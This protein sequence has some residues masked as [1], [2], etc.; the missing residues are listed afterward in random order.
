MSSTICGAFAYTVT[1]NDGTAIDASVFTF[2]LGSGTDPNT[3]SI[4]TSNTA[5]VGVYTIIL[6]G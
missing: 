1:N 2:T 6:T 3:F 4:S 5:K